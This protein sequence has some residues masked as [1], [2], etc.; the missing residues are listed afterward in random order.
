MVNKSCLV[1][2]RVCVFPQNRSIDFPVH[3]RL[4]VEQIQQ[5]AVNYVDT[6]PANMKFFAGNDQ[7]QRAHGQLERANEPPC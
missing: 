5:F 4:H 2:V 1:C 7:E 6:I 3:I